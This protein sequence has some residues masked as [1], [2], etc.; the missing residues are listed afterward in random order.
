LLIKEVVQNYRGRVEF[1]SENWGDSVLAERYGVKKYP[2]VF[3]DDILLAQPNDFGWYGAKG[4]YTPWRDKANHEKFKRDLTRMIE[5]VLG[6]RKDVAARSGQTKVEEEEIAQLPRLTAQDLQ[7]RTLD[8]K[9]LE[10]R[11]VVVEFWA[12]WCPPCRSTLTWLGEL[13]KRYNDRVAVIAIAVESEEKEVRALTV[14]LQL[15]VNVVMG[16][17]SLVNPFGTLGSVP[18]MFVFDPKGKTAAVFYGA[19]DGLHEKVGQ[20]IDSLLKA[21]ASGSRLQ[22]AGGEKS[23]TVE[24][25]FAA[26]RDAMGGEPA[27][28]QIERIKAVADCVGPR[29]KYSTEII[30]VRPDRLFFKQSWATRDPFIAFVNGQYAWLKNEKTGEVSRLDKTTVAGVRGHEF[31]MIAI[32]PLERFKEAR[33]EGFEDFAGA[34]SVKI[35]VTDE[36]GNPV[37]LFFNVKTRLMGGMTL[38]DSR[39]ASG[40]MVKVVFNEWKD[41]GRVRLPSKVTATDKAGDFVLNF[42]EILLNQAEDNIFQVPSE[43][44]EKTR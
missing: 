14:E 34:P 16:S 19:P 12:T 22:D 2:V 20:L 1:K 24:S 8:A 40:E 35:R 32:A 33:V 27:L 42:R 37:Y 26:A 17:E 7:G 25:V 5:L 21:D 4:K 9:S 31:Q 23:L 3:V 44:A 15:P 41:V 29:G 39:S 6:G 11:V 10:G 30:S 13:K 18:R 28:K 43:L 38:A 36:L